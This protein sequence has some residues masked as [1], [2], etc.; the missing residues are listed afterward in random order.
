MIMLIS[1]YCLWK[2]FVMKKIIACVLSIV[3]LSILTA[4]IAFAIEENTATTY[5][6]T[7]HDFDEIP[8]TE[9]VGCVDG[10]R[11][12]LFWIYPATEMTYLQMKCT[13]CGASTVA[14][15]QTGCCN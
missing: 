2:G 13:V 8:G 9:Y 15:T 10:D 11:C 7:V 5:S 12:G 14:A 3:L 6:C 1:C 4:T